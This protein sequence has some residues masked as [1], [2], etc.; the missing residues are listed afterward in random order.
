MDTL[1][2]SIHSN[3][4]MKVN[5]IKFL[6]FNLYLIWVKID[7]FKHERFIKHF[8]INLLNSS[9]NHKSC[10][11]YILAKQIP[12]NRIESIGN[13]HFT[14]DILNPFYKFLQKSSTDWYGEKT[15]C[16]NWVKMRAST[17]NYMNDL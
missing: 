9:L 11:L 14:A 4:Y 13:C 1:R 8:L 16:L 5:Y 2:K 17:G 15:P 7:T 10:E 3:M 12:V 6:I